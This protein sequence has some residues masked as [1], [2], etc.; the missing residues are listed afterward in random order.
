VIRAASRADHDLVVE[1]E[2]L[3][4]GDIVRDVRVAVESWP[5][6]PD[7]TPLKGSCC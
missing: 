5:L 7:P 6:S 3:D 4:Q 1:V 2:V